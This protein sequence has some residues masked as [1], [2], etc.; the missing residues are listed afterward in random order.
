MGIVHSCAIQVQICTQNTAA[1]WQMHDIIN[2]LLQF[3]FTE[4]DKS[5]TAKH[6][7]CCRSR[8]E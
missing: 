7:V 1:A 8:F 2:E 5:S 3:G 4:Q 6:P